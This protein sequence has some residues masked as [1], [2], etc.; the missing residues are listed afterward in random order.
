M[1]D[2]QKVTMELDVIPSLYGNCNTFFSENRKKMYSVL[3]RE[4]F[5]TYWLKGDFYP[6]RYLRD[7]YTII[8]DF[9]PTYDFLFTYNESTKYIPLIK[10]VNVFDYYGN[11][12]TVFENDELLD[13]NSDE[14]KSKY[15]SAISKIYSIC[16]ETYHRLY[17]YTDNSS[18]IE[19]DKNDTPDSMDSDISRI[20]KLNNETLHANFVYNLAF[21]TTNKNSI[22]TIGDLIDKILSKQNIGT[23]IS[24]IG[25]KVYMDFKKYTI[26]YE[27]YNENS[28][29]KL[30]L[31]SEYTLTNDND[32]LYISYKH[33]S[34]ENLIFYT[35]YKY[36]FKFTISRD[37]NNKEYISGI[38]INIEGDIDGKEENT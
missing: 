1:E 14:F 16:D 27:D 37:S 24:K 18:K 26:Y 12:I 5:T 29:P 33:L 7:Y 10:K 6:F 8:I 21:K 22:K 2:K 38:D 35:D 28:N 32:M 17:S 3:N 4:R 34:I 25:F 36:K 13:N 9:V 11:K 19:S 20:V 15:Y 31:N 30:T 23:R